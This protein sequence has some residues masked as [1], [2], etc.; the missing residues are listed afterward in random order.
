MTTEPTPH[1]SLP[2]GD[3]QASIAIAGLVPILVGALLVPARSHVGVADL[4]LVLMGVVVLAALAGGS[5]AGAVAAVTA[6]LSL[7]FFLTRPYLTLRMASRDDIETAVILAVVGTAVGQYAARFR[8]ARQTRDRV[9]QGVA[10]IHRLA[11]LAVTGAEPERV[12]DACRRELAGL[13][14]LRACRFEPAPLADAPSLPE[15]PHHHPLPRLGRDGAIERP[16]GPVS[17][18]RLG[19]GAGTEIPE[20]GLELAVL[21]GGRPAGRFVLV[22]EPGEGL[23][24][25]R[26]LIAVALA[27]QVGLALAGASSTSTTSP[28]SI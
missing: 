17:V 27:D 25:E 3:E 7:D 23:D 15:A 22:P 26:G 9:R 11:E 14:E 18:V 6:T 1:R 10:G 24:P 4:A 21:S 13:I 20:G 28:S 8:A 19:R 5:A 2:D 12:I 16:R